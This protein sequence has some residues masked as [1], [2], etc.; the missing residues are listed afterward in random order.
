MSANSDDITKNEGFVITLAD[1][2]GRKLWVKVAG[3]ES[4]TYHSHFLAESPD[5]YQPAT[6]GRLREPNNASVQGENSLK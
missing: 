6:R 5:K 1:H 2:G 4:Y 3:A